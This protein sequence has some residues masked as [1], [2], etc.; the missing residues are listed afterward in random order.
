MQVIQIS[1]QRY[2]AQRIS[3]IDALSTIEATGAIIEEV[4]HAVG[5]D[6]RVGANFSARLSGLVARASKRYSQPPSPS[7]CSTL[8]PSR[9]STKTVASRSAYFFNT[10]TNKVNEF[11]FLASLV[12]IDPVFGRALPFSALLSRQTRATPAN[13]L[14]SRSLAI[15]F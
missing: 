8:A 2:V 9:H 15:T 11:P 10:T 7:R 12:L 3:S 13:Q 1:N 4:A 6:V 5:R 14:P